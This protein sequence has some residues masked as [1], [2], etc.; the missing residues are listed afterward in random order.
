PESVDR[1]ASSLHLNPS[2]LLKSSNEIRIARALGAPLLLHGSLRADAGHGELLLNYQLVDGTGRVRLE[3][4]VRVPRTTPFEPAPLVD[5]AIHDLLRKVDPLHAEVIQNPAVSA[6]VLAV[7]AAGKARFLKGDFKDSEAPLREAAM[8]APAFSN[9]VST[10]AACLRRLGSE[11]AP[12]AA[13]WA[14]MAAQA[15][16]DRWAEVRAMALRAYLAKDRGDLDESQRLR[17]SSLA[18]ARSIGDTDGEIVATNH[19]GLIAAERGRDAEAQAYYERALDLCRTSGDRIYQALI[20][21]NLANLALK[22]GELAAASTRYQ[23]SLQIQQDLDNRW[24]EALA[25]NNLAVVALMTRDLPRADLL[26]NKALGLRDEVGDRSGQATC[27]RNLGILDLMKDQ[28]AEAE[29]CYTR[30]LAMAQQAGLRTVAAE[31]QFYLSDLDRRLGR[32]GPARTGYQKVL[33]L[34]PAGVTPGVRDNALAG[35]AECLVRQPRPDAR[36]AARILA[37][38]APENGDSP[39]VLRARAWLETASGRPDRARTFLDRA[40]ADPQRQAPEIQGEL[41]SLRAR[42]VGEKG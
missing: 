35:Q 39:Y 32:F 5:P 3:G 27:L 30:A 9:A 18:L 6:E 36:K 8:R 41:R 2:D 7:Y 19:L 34:L 17:E 11:E 1:V 22:R 4:T 40:L 14:L 28:T 13:N 29:H 31:C 26:L 24:G 25:M 10:Y 21:N 33:A 42:L 37:G 12:L 38:I 20:E 16:G 23:A 15:A